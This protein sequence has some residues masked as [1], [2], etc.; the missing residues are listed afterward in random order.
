MQKISG[1]RNSKLCTETL[2]QNRIARNLKMKGFIHYQVIELQQ[3][4]M[5]IMYYNFFM[6]SI[7]L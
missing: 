3:Q 4:L 5:S 7:V 2:L 1:K 6:Q